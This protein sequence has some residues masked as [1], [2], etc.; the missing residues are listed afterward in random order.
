MGMIGVYDG[1]CQRILGL[2]MKRVDKITCC[3]GGV[4]VE[5]ESAA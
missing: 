5:Y 3:S 1:K 2:V 4:V